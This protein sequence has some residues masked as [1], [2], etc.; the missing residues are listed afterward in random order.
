MLEEK[1]AKEHGVTGPKK[2][3]TLQ[4]TGNVKRI[5]PASQEVNLQIAEKKM[6]HML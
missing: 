3:L 5:E 6:R 1:V 2:P 4:W